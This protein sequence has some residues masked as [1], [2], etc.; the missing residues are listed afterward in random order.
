MA[1][2]ILAIG[3]YLMSESFNNQKDIIAIGVSVDIALLIPL[4]YFFMIRNSGIPKLT[5]VPVFVLSLVLAYQIVPIEHQNTLSY[6]E[7][8]LI[9]VELTVIGLLIYHVIK[10]GRDLDQSKNSLSSFPEILK[11]I[12]EKRGFRGIQSSLI[13]SE[14]S[15]FYYTFAG[16]GSPA[17]L[18][19]NEFSYDKESGYRTI[20]IVILFLLPVETVAFHYLISIWSQTLAW[21]LTAISAY[22]VFFILGDRNS[23]RHRPITLTNDSILLPIGLR[24]KTEI[25]FDQIKNIEI[26]EADSSKEDFANLTSFGSGNIL[27]IL[28]EKL[29]IRGIYGIKKHTDRLS[30]SIDEHERFLQMLN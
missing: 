12:L 21:V 30:L 22:S 20:F 28:K 9:P 8:L 15:L 3:F 5:L 4:T 7:Y 14:A 19:K 29:T 27:I 10:I 16:W 17:P 2:V 13:S 25:S 6:I 23:M 1:S 11:N 18:A 24:W 26:R